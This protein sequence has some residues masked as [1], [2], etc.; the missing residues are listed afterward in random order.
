MFLDASQAFYLVFVE[1]FSK[2]FMM[3]A[4]THWFVALLY[5]Y[6]QNRK[7]RRGGLITLLEKYVISHEQNT[8]FSLLILDY[9]LFRFIFT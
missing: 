7:S 2:L 5:Q 6:M 4:C 1:S 3:A 8:S 9:T